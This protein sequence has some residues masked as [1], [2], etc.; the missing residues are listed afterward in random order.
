VSDAA[1]S[2]DR[3]GDL[4]DKTLLKMGVRTQVREEQLRSALA[5][6]VGPALSPMCRAISLE[7]GALLIATS[8]SSLAHQLQLESVKLIA[9]L[10]ASLGTDAVRRLRFT[11]M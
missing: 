1:R 5:A 3:V 10:N 2:P 4:L 6:I 7:R 9:A 8:N 11:S